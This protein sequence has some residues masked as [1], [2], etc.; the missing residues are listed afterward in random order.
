MIKK[1]RQNVTR[2]NNNLIKVV[3]ATYSC[4]SDLFRAISRIVNVLSPKSI[5]TVKIP[6]NAN[7]KDRIPNPSTPRYLVEYI[8]V[9]N[10]KTYPTI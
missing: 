2:L 10:P 1:I 4:V 7:A 9:K 6:V 5:K 3:F 8:N